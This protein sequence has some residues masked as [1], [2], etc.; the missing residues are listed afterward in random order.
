M[1]LPYSTSDVA[2]SESVLAVHCQTWGISA[3]NFH[4]GFD[5][6]TRA[7]FRGNLWKLIQLLSKPNFLT[8]RV[9]E[10]PFQKQLTNLFLW[11]VFSGLS[12][13]GGPEGPAGGR[14]GH[15]VGEG[16]GQVLHRGGG[17]FLRRIL[18][19]LDRR[20]FL[21]MRKRRGFRTMRILQWFLMLKRNSSNYSRK[22]LNIKDRDAPAQ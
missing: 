7:K 10:A 11:Q 14:D 4:C 16:E 9:L 18:S 21:T 19:M 5:E 2:A 22:G 12:A 6:N 8:C 1:P 13:A 17:E 3:K 20:S 15:H